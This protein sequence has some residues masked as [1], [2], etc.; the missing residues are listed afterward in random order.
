[1]G[2]FDWLFGKKR[3]KEAMEFFEKQRKLYDSLAMREGKKSASGYPVCP[4]CS[5]EFSLVETMEQEQI[6]GLPVYR[7][8]RCQETF[9]L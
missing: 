9:K 8:P 4:N 1:M 5:H 7:C 6:P 3:E 2:I